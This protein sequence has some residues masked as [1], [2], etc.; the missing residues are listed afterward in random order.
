MNKP[1][2]YIDDYRV[3][4]IRNAVVA[5]HLTQTVVLEGM[6][7]KERGTKS[8]TDVSTQLPA[9]LIAPRNPGNTVQC[10]FATG[11]GFFRRDFTEN[12][13]GNIRLVLVTRNFGVSWL[14]SVL[15]RKFSGFGR[16]IGHD[17]VLPHTF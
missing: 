12:I 13:S 17:S 4:A 11:H 14:S 3:P 1:S 15:R 10:A 6:R 16:K 8:D 5:Y 9:P 2:N 7:R